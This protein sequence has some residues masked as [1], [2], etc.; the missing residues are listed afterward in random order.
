MNS[1]NPQV[2]REHSE[3]PLLKIQTVRGQWM[4]SGFKSKGL[5]SAAMSE[6]LGSS[7]TFLTACLG[8]AGLMGFS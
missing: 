5:L 3:E 1:S 6:A 4:E 8:K 2:S 7:L